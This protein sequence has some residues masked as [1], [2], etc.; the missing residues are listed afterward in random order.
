MA[1][2]KTAPDRN[3]ERESN[4]E[5]NQPR[6]CR[7]QAAPHPL[8]DGSSTAAPDNSRRLG[9]PELVRARKERYFCRQAELH[10]FTLSP[11]GGEVL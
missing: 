8:G 7:P 5:D 3:E 9:N 2:K 10:G 1:S 6:R 11:V 4:A